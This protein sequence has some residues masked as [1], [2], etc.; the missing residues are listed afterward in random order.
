MM[1]SPEATAIY[2]L[3]A[4]VVPLGLISA[5]AARVSQGARFERPCQWL[6]MVSLV[7]V[8]LSTGASL[9]LEPAYWLVAAGTL[10]AMVLTVL[11]DFRGKSRAH[12]W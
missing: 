2:Y 7:I 10:S 9:R 5:C 12:A 4:V 1:L 8:A 3:L 6:F 11:C